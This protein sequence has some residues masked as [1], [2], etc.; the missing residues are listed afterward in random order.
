MLYWTV[1][2]CTPCTLRLEL[3]MRKSGHEHILNILVAGESWGSMV[4]IV[5]KTWRYGATKKPVLQLLNNTD[6]I[7]ISLF[8]MLV[9]T[10]PL[11]VGSFQSRDGEGKVTQSGWETGRDGIQKTWTDMAPIGEE[12][13]S[14]DP[15]RHI[16]IILSNK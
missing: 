11:T 5:H 10:S 7:Y 12:E 8:P 6:T 3:T 14:D 16:F 9:I 13:D 2:H 1:R 4:H 15:P